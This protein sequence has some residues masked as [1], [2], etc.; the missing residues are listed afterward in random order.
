MGRVMFRYLLVFPVVFR[1]RLLFL[2]VECNWIRSYYKI[3][4]VLFLHP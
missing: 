1:N 4:E 3:L 2:G